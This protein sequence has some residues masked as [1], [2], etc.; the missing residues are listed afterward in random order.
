MRT[1]TSA[2]AVAAMILGLAGPVDAQVR[3][4][5]PSPPPGGQPQQQ[6]QPQPASD[7]FQF[8]VCNKTKNILFVGMLYK[9]SGDS[10]R[11]MGWAQ[12]KPGD[13]GPV[14][15]TYPRDSFFWYAENGPGTITYAGTDAQGCVNQNDAFDR[16]VSGNYSCQ[17]G[18]KIVGFHKITP[19]Q[20]Q[21]GITL[22]D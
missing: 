9:V 22:L 21:N 16:T 8:K 11:Y 19:E 6:P 10:W 2:L 14:Q 13:C 20:I 18:E 3:P 7:Q 5:P 17:P 1:W 12:Y 4:T 15:G